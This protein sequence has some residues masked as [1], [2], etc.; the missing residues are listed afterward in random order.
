MKSTKQVALLLG[1]SASLFFAVTFVVNRLMSLSGG[2]WIWSASFRFF[3]MLPIFLTVVLSRKGFKPLITEI[4]RNVFQWLLWGTIGFGVFYASL[5]FA[6]DFSPSWLVASTWQIT[7]IAGLLLAPLLN[8]DVKSLNG[9][10]FL[11]SGIIL[12]GIIIMQINH[13]QNLMLNDAFL[14]FISIVI[15]AFSY[16][17]GNRK[18]MQITKGKLDVYQRI[19]GMLI[20]SM[21]FWVLICILEIERNHTF[22][23]KEQLV[24]TFIVAVFSGVIATILFFKA[25][26]IVSTNEKHL[27]TIEA[28]QS[29]EV[30]FALLGETLFLSL[31]IPNNVELLGIAFVIA[32]MILHAIKS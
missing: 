13:A 17:L 26:D 11:F 10:S 24:Q 21:P 19:L 27:S 6:A 31:A 22:P 1:V 8:P 16:P 14:G 5:T 30:V 29:T 4:R 7:I 3:W 12:L 25:T 23:Q 18:M 15:A 2:S 28:T 32:G 20:C 9:K